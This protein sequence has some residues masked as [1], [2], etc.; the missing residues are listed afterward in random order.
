MMGAF[1]LLAKFKFLRGTPLDVFAYSTERR[2]EKALI[3][4]YE[5]NISEMLAGLKAENYD[6]AIEI[7]LLPRKIRG[8]GHVKMES[9][10]IVQ[11][12]AEALWTSFRGIGL[13]YEPVR[14]LE[15]V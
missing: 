5:K 11:K 3:G 6:V 8:F 10:T 13:S 2:A 7:A 14:I 12:E 15:R 1:W 4:D 9:I